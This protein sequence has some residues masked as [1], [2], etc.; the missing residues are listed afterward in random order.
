MKPRCLHSAYT[1]QGGD[2][3]AKK[4]KTRQQPLA[5][6]LLL[7]WSTKKT[8]VT[9]NPP[10][11]SVGDS[12]MRTMKLPRFLLNVQYRTA[13]C[14]SFFNRLY[15]LWLICAS[16]LL[17]LCKGCAAAYDGP[18]VLYDLGRPASECLILGRASHETGAD[19]VHQGGRGRDEGGSEG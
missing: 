15:V 11:H 16:L 19:D 1:P 17:S 10:G 14:F 3:G 18:N 4:S 12:E 8:P 5:Q 13:I 6:R 7:P 9:M 2:A